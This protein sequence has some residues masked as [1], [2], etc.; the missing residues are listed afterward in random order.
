MHSLYH[1]KD[2]EVK[3]AREIEENVEIQNK[4]I[5]RGITII[6]FIIITLNWYAWWETFNQYTFVIY[7]SQNYWLKTQIKII[8][9]IIF[10]IKIA[11]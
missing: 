3:I 10:I 4:S 7:I 5:L 11:R 1:I 9:K 8:S 2:E 6:P